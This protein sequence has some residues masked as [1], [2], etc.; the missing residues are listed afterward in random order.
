[1]LR[2]SR[3][4][5]FLLC[6]AVLLS[7]SGCYAGNIDQ[8][9]SPPEPAEEYRQLQELIDREISSGS[10]YAAPIRGNYRQSVQLFDLS[11]DGSN[12]ALA[13]F[14]TREGSLK[15]NIY[16]VSGSEYRLVQTLMEEGRS[17]GRVDFADLDSDRRLDL[18]VAWQIASGMSILSVYS[19]VNWSGTLLMSADCT[20][21]VTGDLTRDG[22]E[23]LLILRAANTGTYLTDMYTIGP[24]GDPQ[25]ATA[26]LSGGIRDLERVRTVFI[27]TGYP[28]LLVESSLSS[29]D[30][31]TDLLVYREGAL[32]NLT[33][34][35]SSGISET[36]RV[37]N[38]VFS[39]DID[40]DGIT[41]IPFPQQL[42]NQG[43]ETQWSTAWY[44][45]DVS[46]RANQIMTTYHCVSDHW[47]LELPSGW[48]AGL[49][50]RQDDSIPGERAVV[51]SRLGGDGSI[52]DLLTIYAISGEN[53]SERAKL[54][55]RFV[56]EESASTVYAGEI[57]GEGIIDKSGIQ[58]RFHIIY[59]EWS[60]GSI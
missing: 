24:D 53:R 15:I 6:L 60:A 48:D 54:P 21:F 22:H 57:L 19:L 17:I 3:P 42:Y 51:L 44:R 39:Q 29:G 55:G 56:L 8:Y 28:A 26:A 50:V 2:I 40:G 9:F 11:G 33:M 59:T 16:A 32:V 35:R 12:E 31:V 13:F 47:Y 4:V 30:L 52:N 34:N 7:L 45:Y 49:T 20:E 46:G 36:R 14:R 43:G 1:M 5:S 18:I 27:G 38:Q 41:E 37:N 23:E 10:E 25:A 58:S